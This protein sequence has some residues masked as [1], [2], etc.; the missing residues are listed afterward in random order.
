MAKIF[1]DMDEFMDMDFWIKT[2]IKES[3]WEELKIIF[4]Y[5]SEIQNKNCYLE[6]D[7]YGKKCS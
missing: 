4:G 1:K 3:D 2:C 7:I 5:L 6:G